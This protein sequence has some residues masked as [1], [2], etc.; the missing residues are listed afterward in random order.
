MFRLSEATTE[1]L[2]RQAP[3][4]AHTYMSAAVNDI[5]EI[6]GKGY[7]AKRPELGGSYM[8]T[9]ALDFAAAIIAGAIEQV[10][11]ALQSEAAEE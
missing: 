10:A 9:A 6:F 1:I 3:M 11:S 7:A 8:Q 4:T 2:L 5:D